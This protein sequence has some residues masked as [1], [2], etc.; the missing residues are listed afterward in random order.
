V[1]D[2]AVR[3]RQGEADLKAADRNARTLQFCQVKVLS[4]T[5]SL[6]SGKFFMSLS[7]HTTLLLVLKCLHF[8][9]AVLQH[10]HLC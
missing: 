1:C 4:E 10:M 7:A 8:Q 5:A 2:L 6:R 3:G 9:K